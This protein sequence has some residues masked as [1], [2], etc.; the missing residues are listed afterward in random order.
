M[1]HVGE[2]WCDS[3]LFYNEQLANE[4]QQQEEFEMVENAKRSAKRT[5]MRCWQEKSLDDFDFDVTS[6]ICRKCLRE[7]SS[8]INR[9]QF[10]NCANPDCQ[11]AFEPID[12]F[13]HF[14]S[15]CDQDI[16]QGIC[17]SC[18]SPIDDANGPADWHG[19]CVNCSQISPS[20]PD[21]CQGCYTELNEINFS[22]LR[23]GFCISCEELMKTNQCT[24][25]DQP[26]ED[27]N[28][29]GWCK[30][31]EDRAVYPCAN[32]ATMPVKA[33]GDLCEECS[34]NNV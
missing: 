18:T 31:C 33:L 6:A 9:P 8:N 21:L 7:D 26:A 27:V 23:K 5:C 30:E 13:D 20:K 16:R 15:Q 28:Y 24:S 12:D 14:C 22:R 11:T 34:E 17:T 29:R 1:P 19:H 2:Y 32:C 3:C 25:C 4:K 10:T